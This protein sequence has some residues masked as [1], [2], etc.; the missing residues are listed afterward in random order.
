MMNVNMADLKLIRTKTKAGMLDC[1][2]ALD[3]AKG[4]VAI[5]EALLKEWGLAG[6]EDR[7]ERAA[8][9]GRIFISSEDSRAAMVELACETDFVSRGDAFQEAGA[10]MA[11]I[12]L[13]GKLLGP[14]AETA[15]IVAD[16]AA[17]LKE[18]I[19]VRRIDFLEAGA[20]SGSTHICM[21][22]VG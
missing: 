22:T 13:R 18:N 9:E 3:Q 2:K 6:V 8:R 21:P 14:D 16:L 11:G 5:A 20:P 1:T 12:V 7:A 10:R 17:V 19:A 15:G 4:D